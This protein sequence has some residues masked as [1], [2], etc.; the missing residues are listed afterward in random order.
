MGWTGVPGYRVTDKR[1]YCRNLWNKDYVT[2]IKDCMVGTTYYAAA[3][4]IA[5]TGYDENGN[6]TRLPLTE[7]EQYVFAIV[8]KT[9][10]YKGEFLYKEMDE[11]V[12]PCERNCPVSILKLLTATD[13][14]IAVEWRKACWENARTPKLSSVKIGQ[15]IKA[16]L[17]NGKEVVLLK[18]E[19]AYQFKRPFWFSEEEGLYCKSNHIVSFSLVG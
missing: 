19:P 6:Y 7:S 10:T 9:D 4:K 17:F 8:V 16:K 5:K 15:K 13:D 3:R 2:I 11:T 14:K 12:G 18:H 1:E